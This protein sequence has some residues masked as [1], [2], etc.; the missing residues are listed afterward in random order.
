MGLR[1][2]AEYR[3]SLAESN[4]RDSKKFLGDKLYRWA[5][6]SAQLS[7]ENSAKAVISCFRIPSWLHDPSVELEDVLRD[8]KDDI[9]RR[10]EENIVEALKRLAEAASELAPEHGR[11]T[12][13]IIERRVLPSEIYGEPEAQRAVCRAE[14]GCK[15]ADRFVKKW[16]R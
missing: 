14:E 1:E 11:A 6:L 7:V 16:F 3:L 5:V 13:G 10:F 9:S 2:E 15:T 4:L 12:Y 8:W